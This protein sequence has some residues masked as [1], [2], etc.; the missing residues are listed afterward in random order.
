MLI[1]TFLSSLEFP[2]KW[3]LIIFSTIFTDSFKIHCSFYHVS[4]FLNLDRTQSYVYKQTSKVLQ[5]EIN[6]FKM[7]YQN[8]SKIYLSTFQGSAGT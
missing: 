5:E 6:H 7:N 8:K 2:S 4:A 1:D 3:L